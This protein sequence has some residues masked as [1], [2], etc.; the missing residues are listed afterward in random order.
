[1]VKFNKENLW[2]L[3]K[4]KEMITLEK[5]EIVIEIIKY[6]KSNR[7]NSLFTGGNVR[8]TGRRRKQS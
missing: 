2:I 7:E 5:I 4:R 6:E 3:S 8:L 1:M